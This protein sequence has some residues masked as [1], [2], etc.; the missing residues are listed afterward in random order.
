MRSA[1][2]TALVLF[3]GVAMAAGKPTTMKV[4]TTG[5][6]LTWKGGKKIGDSSHNGTIKLKTGEVVATGNTI[7]GGS[8]EIDMATLTNEDLKS[9]EGMKKKL[10]GHLMSPDFFDVTK[11][12]TAKF[13]IT[14]VK[15]LKDGKG[16]HEITGDLTIKDQTQSVTFPAIVK[17]EKG[18]AS[19]EGT[20]I[21]NR[22]KWNLTYG[23]ESFIKKLAADKIIK[24]D[25]EIGLKLTA[26]K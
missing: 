5:S 9:D 3:T 8:F 10:E 12:P 16:T 1:L 13:K 17:F 2:M 6:Q 24:D 21:I 23:S 4:D 25:I 22:T 15:D 26:K 7:T 20:I 18:T 14:A 11:F 19:A